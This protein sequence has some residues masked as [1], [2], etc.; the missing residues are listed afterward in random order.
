[1]GVVEIISKSG[2]EK[3]HNLSRAYKLF[4]VLGRDESIQYYKS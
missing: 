2:L 4:I 1:M 3:I